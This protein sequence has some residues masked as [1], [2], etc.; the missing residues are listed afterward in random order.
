MRLLRA[1]LR[2]LWRPL[3]LALLVATVI[4]TAMIARQQ[5]VSLSALSGKVPGGGYGGVGGDAAS[6]LPLESPTGIGKAAAQEMA[7]LVGAVVMLFLAGAHVAGEWSGRTWKSVL[8][9]ESRRGRVLLSKAVSLWVAGVATLAGLWVLLAVFSVFL[10]MA[11]PL[12]GRPGL[13]AGLRAAG[14]DL[15]R[16]SV[17]LAAFAVLGLCAAVLTRSMLGTVVAGVFFVGVSMEVGNI[18][19]LTRFSPSYWVDGWMRFR[20]P[21]AGAAPLAVWN[22][23]LPPGVPEASVTTGGI[24]LVALAAG[25]SAVTWL[26]FRR[27]D[28]TV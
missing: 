13:T 20:P 24:G 26:R 8:T 17:V 22:T 25:L 21:G 3:P 7:S 16:A 14:P 1:E 9:A 4:L 18:S 15:L 19:Y 10:A 23:G 27:T 2:K 6:V 28:V 5:V 12:A 11:W